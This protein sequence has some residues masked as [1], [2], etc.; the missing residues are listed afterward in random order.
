VDHQIILGK[1][2][3]LLDQPVP[4]LDGEV[5]RDYVKGFFDRRELFLRAVKEFGS[6]LYVLDEA[7]IARRAREFKSAFA[8]VLPRS[9]CFYA[10]KSNYHPFLLGVL[11]GQ[12]YHLDVSSGWELEQALALGAPEIIFSGPAK[13]EQELSLACRHADKV[14]VLMDSFAE[15]SRLEEAA[16]REGVRIKAGVRLMIEEDGLWRKFGIPLRRMAEFFAGSEA[17]SCVDLRGLQFHASWNLDPAKQTGFIQKLGGILADMP[18]E[19]AGAINFI[20][21]GGGYWPARGEWTHPCAT[22]GGKLRQ[23]LE[24]RIEEGLDH[25][26]FSAVPLADFARQISESL[27]KNIF[28]HVEPEI[29]LEPGRWISNDSMHILL[30]VLDKKA[31]DVVIVDGATSAVGWERYE[32]D[33]CPALNL[34]RPSLDERKCMVFGS[35]CTPHDLWGY[36]YFGDNIELGDVL[37]VPD[38]GAYTYSLRQHFIKPLPRQV[39]L[40]GAEIKLF[41]E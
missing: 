16:A 38:Q 13:T 31:D 19:Q 30:Q 33:Y 37:L 25:C 11:A 14:T 5:L 1:A 24:P 7:V 27:H 41:Q 26:C 39:I 2:K 23:C 4:L 28:P 15:R 8:S 29:Y 21:I 18:A 3:L 22:P 32:N 20:D 6:P 34:S 12:G 17:Y 35:L 9:K 10:L 36:S 40:S